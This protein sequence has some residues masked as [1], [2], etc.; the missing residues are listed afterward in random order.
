MITPSKPQLP[1]YAGVLLTATRGRL[2]ARERHGLTLRGRQ[3][4]GSQLGLPLLEKRPGDLLHRVDT[5]ADLFGL[6]LRRIVRTDVDTGLAAC[7]RV[8]KI[9]RVE[10][11]VAGRRARWGTLSQDDPSLRSG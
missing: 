6:F 5:L 4:A 1:A 8:I 11:V 10:L 7:G 2:A 9:E 3:L